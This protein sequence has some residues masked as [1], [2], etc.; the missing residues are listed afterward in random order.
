MKGRDGAVLALVPLVTAFGCGGSSKDTS[1]EASKP[2]AQILDDTAGALKRVH[3][4]RLQGTQTIDDQKTAIR[5]DLEP[6]A[7]VSLAYDQRGAAASIIAVSGSVYIKA[8]ETFWKKQGVGRAGTTLAGKWFKAPTSEAEFKDLTKGLDV[9]T[10][11]RCLVQNHGTLAKGGTATVNGQPAVVIVDKGDRPG[12]TPG[13]LF[14]ATKG[15]PVPLRIVATGEQRPGGIKD[16]QCNDPSSR[17]HAGDQLSFTKY[18]Q[19]LKIAPPLGALDL[20]ELG[21]TTQ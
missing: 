16:R 1:D 3:S 6:P 14:V 12:S 2:P 20:T 7:K 9:A 15:E 18:D 8:N 4:V 17:T 13:K 21:R 11:S 10:L 19:A 5:A